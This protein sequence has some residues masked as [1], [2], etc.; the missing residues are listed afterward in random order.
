MRVLGASG[1]CWLTAETV[2][3]KVGSAVPAVASLSSDSMYSI[4]L[5]ASSCLRA[6]TRVDVVWVLDDHALGTFD[7]ADAIALTPG[8]GRFGALLGGALAGH[9]ADIGARQAQAAR[10][11]DL[12]VTP[13]DAAVAGLTRSGPVRAIVVPATQ[14]PEQLWPRLARRDPVCLVVD[15]ADDGVLSDIRLFTAD[16]IDAAGPDIAERFRRGTSSTVAEPGPRGQ[17]VVAIFAPTDRFVI[18]GNGPNADALQAAATLQGWQVLRSG[19]VTTA[20]GLMADLTPVDMVVVMGHDVE[21]S[22]RMLAAA[23]ASDAG[24]IGA[25]GSAK[26]QQQ[27]ADWLA[28]QGVTDLDRVNGPA[29]L[30]IGAQSPAEI[31]VSILAQV[32]AVR[33]L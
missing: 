28:Y 27:R 3:A 33:N 15:L 4:A 7:A 26:M 6:G 1:A 17:R 20:T 29:G 30:A 5:T 8:G 31:A 11:I 16:T 21:L 13:V 32:I 9:L 22:S 2:A 14:L 24:Y 10:L 12:E 25:L 23:L 18:A 19:E